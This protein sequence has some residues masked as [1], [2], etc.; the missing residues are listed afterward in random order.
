[1]FKQNLFNVYESKLQS[2][3]KRKTYLLNRPTF[4]MAEYLFTSLVTTLITN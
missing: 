3:L 2:S 4:T 1:M